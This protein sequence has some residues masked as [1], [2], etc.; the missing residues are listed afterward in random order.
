MQN[1][2]NHILLYA[3]TALT[4]NTA[5]LKNVTN[6]HNA[7][8]QSGIIM[9]NWK[10]EYVCNSYTIQNKF[11]PL[12]WIL[13]QILRAFYTFFVYFCIS[14]CKPVTHEC[15][16]SRLLRFRSLAQIAAYSTFISSNLFNAYK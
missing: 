15:Y 11:L 12:N 9:H 16:L 13:L 6:L 3:Y 4:E 5:F 14:F 7:W 10:A 2:G 1:G 8:F